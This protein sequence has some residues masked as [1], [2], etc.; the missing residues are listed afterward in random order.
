MKQK[1]VMKMN[2]ENGIQKSNKSLLLQLLVNGLII[3]KSSR[4]SLWLLMKVFINNAGK[5]E[6]VAVSYGSNIFTWFLSNQD[7]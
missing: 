3:T 2:C 6:N 7:L 5:M 1:T 4:W